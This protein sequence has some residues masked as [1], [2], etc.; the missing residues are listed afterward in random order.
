MLKKFLTSIMLKMENQKR[1]NWW[2]HFDEIFENGITYAK[3]KHCPSGPK[4]RYK[5]SGQCNSTGNMKRHMLNKHSEKV[6]QTALEEEEFVFSQEKFRQTLV[7]W[8]V[9]CNQNFNVV[10]TPA[11]QRLINSLNPVAE[12][13][14]D[15][16]VQ[17]DIMLAFQKFLER[18]RSQWMAGHPE[19]CW[20]LLRYEDTGWIRIGSITQHL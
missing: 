14:S 7:E 17:A 18:Y 11:F 8:I 10:E 1:S 9:L 15:K 19:M 16:T 20:H 12:L 4:G 3:C 2:E 13:I 5:V 6:L